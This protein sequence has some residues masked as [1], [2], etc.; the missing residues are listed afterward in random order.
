MNLE[1]IT[2]NDITSSMNKIL[3][4]ENQENNSKIVGIKR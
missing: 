3:Q 4:M 2:Y 1:S